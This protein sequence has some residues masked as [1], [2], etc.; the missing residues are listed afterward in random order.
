MDYRD[1][2]EY[3]I[4]AAFASEF[5][6]E[7]EDWCQTDVTALSALELLL[8]S[9]DSWPG[10]MPARYEREGRHLSHVYLSWAPRSNWRVSL[11]RDEPQRGG[12]TPSKARSKQYEGRGGTL[13]S[14]VLSAG[15]D[16]A[17]RNPRTGTTPA[18]DSKV[19]TNPT[20]NT[21]TPTLSSTAYQRY[22]SDQEMI[23][24]FASRFNV[25]EADWCANEASA[26]PLLSFLWHALAQ[27]SGSMQERPDAIS[28]PNQ[29]IKINHGAAYQWQVHLDRMEP[30]IGG[31]AP[32]IPRCTPYWAREATLPRAILQ[33]GIHFA[34]REPAWVTR[35]RIPEQYR[36]P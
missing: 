34:K 19:A 17:V 18:A 23:K 12:L 27:G 36:Y 32:G 21:G 2:S 7:V 24:E 33:A 6:V 35:G 4:C 5:G 9:V 16:F 20:R 29:Y 1:V 14:A 13:A 26:L 15:I 22:R 3:D 28:R 10:G 30:Q 11:Y 25:P 8:S 31:T